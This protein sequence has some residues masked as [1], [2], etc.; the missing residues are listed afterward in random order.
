MNWNAA[1]GEPLLLLGAFALKKTEDYWALKAKVFST[2]MCVGAEQ[3]NP[4]AHLLTIFHKT[5]EK[6]SNF[7]HFD[8]QNDLSY[9]G[10]IL[11]KKVEFWNFFTI[12]A[13]LENHDMVEYQV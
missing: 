9:F 5:E 7:L 11:S 12:H 13:S 1:L 2:T 4:V 3:K 10:M 6:F 8:L